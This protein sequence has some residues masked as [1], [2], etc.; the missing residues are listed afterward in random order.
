MPQPQLFIK[1]KHRILQ[2]A[3]FPKDQLSG[4]KLLPP[5][6]AKTMELCS[7]Y[8]LAWAHL[9]AYLVYWKQLPKPHQAIHPPVCKVLGYLLWP[10]CRKEAD[11]LMHRELQRDAVSL[12][13]PDESSGAWRGRWSC[14]MLSGSQG[15]GKGMASH[16][17]DSLSESWDFLVW[18]R[19]S[20]NPQ[21]AKEKEII[22][23]ESPHSKLQ[24]RTLNRRIPFMAG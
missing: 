7:V 15:A 20:C 12:Q 18:K 14:W 17:Y 1:E 6:A 3:C 4:R 11:G 19:L 2:M 21:T 5:P 8:Q 16:P 9:L 22:W 23:K 10:S 24:Q 13:C